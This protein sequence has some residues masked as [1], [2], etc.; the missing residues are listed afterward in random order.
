[1]WFVTALVF[2]MFRNEN[3]NYTLHPKGCSFHF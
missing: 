1:V 3:S 2:R